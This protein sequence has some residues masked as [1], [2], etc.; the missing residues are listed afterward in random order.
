MTRQ[1]ID[2][3]VYD[4][5]SAKKLAGFDTGLE[6]DHPMYEERGMYLTPQKRI[7]KYSAGGGLSHV[8]FSIPGSPHCPIKAPIVE[9]KPLSGNNG[10][11]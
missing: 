3:I 5:T 9:Q 11:Y 4:T 6:T 1:E 8:G 2:G 7:F 10:E